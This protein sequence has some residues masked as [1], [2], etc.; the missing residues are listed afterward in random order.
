M[1][2][3]GS[4]N[5]NERVDALF[6]ATVLERV[7]DRVDLIYSNDMRSTSAPT[8]KPTAEPTA[9]LHSSDRVM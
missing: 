7:M 9:K 8:A 3:G 5:G 4:E 1:A 6:G 2:D